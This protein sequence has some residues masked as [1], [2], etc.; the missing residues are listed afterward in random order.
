MNNTRNNHEKKRRMMC[1]GKTVQESV[2]IKEQ[3]IKS[4][5]LFF[6]LNLKSY[7]EDCSYSIHLKKIKGFSSMFSHRS[8]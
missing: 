2:L 8:S 7:Q 6:G 5:D 3:S 1:F 4:I